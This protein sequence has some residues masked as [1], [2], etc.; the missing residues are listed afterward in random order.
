MFL[1]VRGAPARIQIEPKTCSEKSFENHAFLLRFFA[2]WDPKMDPKWVRFGHK[3]E[4]EIHSKIQ[5]E[6]LRKSGSKSAPK[7]GRACQNWRKS[8]SRKHA[9]M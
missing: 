6:N 8:G 9:N 2:I 3:I 7:A 1:E 4:P 5:W